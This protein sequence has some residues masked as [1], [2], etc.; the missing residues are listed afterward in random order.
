MKP[1]SGKKDN[2][3]AIQIKVGTGGRRLGPKA[4]AEEQKSLGAL[5]KKIVQVFSNKHFP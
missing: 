1:D 2:F 4:G 5:L 3:K